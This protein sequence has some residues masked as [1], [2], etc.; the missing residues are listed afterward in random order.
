MTKHM[1]SNATLQ[2]ALTSWRSAAQD[3][4][5]PDEA[6]F[7]AANA[8]N[9]ATI[10]NDAFTLDV[11]PGGDFVFRDVGATLARY[12]ELD[13]PGRRP[14]F[15]PAGTVSDLIHRTIIQVVALRS[16]HFALGRTHDDDDAFEAICLPLI[17]ASGAT[18][19]FGALARLGHA[20]LPLPAAA[21]K[22]E[23]E[24]II[25]LAAFQSEVEKT[26]AAKP[27]PGGE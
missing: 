21:P 23:I 8:G 18:A 27:K 2:V 20:A 19:V 24:A 10:M 9:R 17:T 3:R 16:P 14:P 1:P 26:N 22:V 25:D 7:H 11:G 12:I 15:G 13:D 4:G 6:A 5:V